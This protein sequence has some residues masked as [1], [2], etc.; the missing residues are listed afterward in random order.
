MKWWI[1]RAVNFTLV[2]PALVFWTFV[3][4]SVFLGW[5]S[6]F[7]VPIAVVIF[8]LIERRFEDWLRSARTEF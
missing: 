3:W 1:L 5:L 2:V 4:T 8:F 7:S 6:F